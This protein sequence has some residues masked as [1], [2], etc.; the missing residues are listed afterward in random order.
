M[1]RDR[2]PPRRAAQKT[3]GA[4]LEALRKALA[5]QPNQLAGGMII[6]LASASLVTVESKYGLAGEKRRSRLCL[7][8]YFDIQPG[9]VPPRDLMAVDVNEG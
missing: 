1:A 2:L 5:V 3:A 7:A 6:F 9:K 4:R 8:G